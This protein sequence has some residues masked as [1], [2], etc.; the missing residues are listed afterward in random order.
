MQRQSVSLNGAPPGERREQGDHVP[1][2]E[3]TILAGLTIVHEDDP[4]GFAW[5]TEDAGKVGDG[6]VVGDIED[7][8]SGL[9]IRR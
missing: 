2:L 9:V 5:D 4:G 1:S 8:G 3:P 6:T 7:R